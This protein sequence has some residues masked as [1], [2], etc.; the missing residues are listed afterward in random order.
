MP[1]ITAPTP[2]QILEKE[3]AEIE[4]EIEAAIAELEDQDLLNAEYAESLRLLE[5]R[6][7]KY[8]PEGQIAPLDSLR[9]LLEEG[10]SEADRQY[11]W[12]TAKAALEDSKNQA[13]YL[14]LQL[15][16]LRNQM[17]ITK[18]ELDWESNFA[19]YLD[20]YK[21]SFSQPS[22]ALKRQ[23]EITNLQRDIDEKRATLQRC[24]E[25]INTPE[26]D[27]SYVPYNA[28]Q[29]SEYL[30][31]AIPELQNKLESLKLQPL[32]PDPAYH[33]ALRRYVI[34][35]VK[36]EPVFKEFLE[37]QDRYLTVLEKFKSG[38]CDDPSVAE[39][40]AAALTQPRIVAGEGSIRLV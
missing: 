10:D 36:I 26:G 23:Q 25:W 16:Q 19:P 30:T 22:P 38:I 37:V 24:Q 6:A 35:R 31:R 18:G 3:I 33:E 12:N 20:R 4:A 32:N 28:Y 15:E 17:V 5:T 39:F 40:P 34:S 13:A 27:R 2:T 8:I 29:Q 21:D 14:Q 7:A 1:K 9:R 11:R